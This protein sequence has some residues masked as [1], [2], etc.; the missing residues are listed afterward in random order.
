MVLVFFCSMTTTGAA[1]NHSLLEKAK[2]K[3]GEFGISDFTCHH[4]G[5]KLLI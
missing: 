4:H 3:I 2:P 1:K 5:N